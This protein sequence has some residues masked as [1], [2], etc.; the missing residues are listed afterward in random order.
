VKSKRIAFRTSWN[1]LQVKITLENINLK[2][3]KIEHKI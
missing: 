3:N 1:K 2:G